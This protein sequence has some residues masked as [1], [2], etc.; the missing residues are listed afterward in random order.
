MYPT[1][2]LV[3]KTPMKVCINNKP[4]FQHLCVFGCEAYAQVP[5]EKWSNLD[6]K[7]LKCLFINDDIIVKGYNLWDPM[8]GFFFYIMNVIFREVKPSPIVVEP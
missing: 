8:A 2:A 7:V 4:S 1:S 5:K 3:N 6:N